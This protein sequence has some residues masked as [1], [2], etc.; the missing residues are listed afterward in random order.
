MPLADMAGDFARKAKQPLEYLNSVI[1]STDLLEATI[2]D[3]ESNTDPS[4]KVINDLSLAGLYVVRE[5]LS[6]S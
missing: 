3:L 2:A 1:F 5:E 4:H 6:K